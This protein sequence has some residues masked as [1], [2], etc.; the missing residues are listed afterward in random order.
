MSASSAATARALP[1]LIVLGATWGSS[2]L[3]MKVILDETGP[4]EVVAGRLFFGLLSVAAFVFIRRARLKMSPTLFV[5]ISFLAFVGNIAPF[6]LIAWGQQHI[7]SGV[8]SVLNAMVP[9]FTAIFAAAL[10]AD[11]RFTA[12]RVAGL[13]LALAGVGLLTG[14]EVVNI[15]RSSVLG[16]FA[17]VGA[18]ACYGMG[19]VIARDLLSKQDPLGLGL[20]Q[21]MFGFVYVLPLLF[22]IDGSPDFSLSLKATLSLI[23]LGVGGTGL[24][25]ILY[26]W[27]IEHIG[28][29]RASLVTYIVPVVALFL[30][31]IVL[32][33]SIGAN[34][35]AGAALIIGGVAI[36]MR[37]R[38][39]VR[40]PAGGLEPPMGEEKA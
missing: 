15:T 17:I 25:Y 27:L 39:P 22:L 37:G 2:F 20:M 6:G 33:E 13:V 29:V 38:I 21:L 36:V 32:N 16:Q 4:L 7:D 28:S 18:A 14:D 31:W 9:I 26:L 1:G 23:G 12:G 24:G 11:E 19:S 40:A 8:A 10:L 3:F 30:G 34:T 5:Q 35:I